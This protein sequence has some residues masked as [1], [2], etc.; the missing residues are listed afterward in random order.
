ME[1]AVNAVKVD[2]MPYREASRH[3]NVPLETLRQRVIGT[4]EMGA[5][6][7]PPTTF[8]TQEEDLLSNHLIDMA[9]MG[10]GLSREDT[11]RMA[12]TMAE[13]MGKNHSFKNEAAG[14]GWYEGFRL[15]HPNLTIRTPRPL[16]YCRAL[17]SNKTQLAIFFSKLGGIYGKLNLLTKPMQIF[18]AD[19]S[20]IGIV[21]KPGKV[22]AQLGRKNVYSVSAAERGKTHTILACVSASGSSLPPMMVYPRKRKLQRRCS[23][24]YPVCNFCEW[25]DYLE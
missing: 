16:S 1:A 11:M 18:N 22:I 7:G 2:G 24:W 12:Y 17:C 15:R 8:T 14:R 19:E 25:V 9:D 4:V 3:Y 6:S 23:E 10:V 21:Y 5:K 13:K 20:G